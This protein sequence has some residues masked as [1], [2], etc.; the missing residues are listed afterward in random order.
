MFLPLI[1]ISKKIVKM[2]GKCLNEVIDLTLR[3]IFYRYGKIVGTHPGYFIIVP[4]LV[5]VLCFTGVQQ[6][7]Y[8]Y[9]PEY[10][11]SPSNGQ[12]KYER[13]LVETYFP[14]NYSSFKANRI[15]RAGKL[16]RL[17]IKAKDNGSMLRTHIWD[18]MLYLDQVRR[19]NF[20]TT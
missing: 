8:N 3:K 2:G 6:M 12:A 5:T 14:T 4:I 20:S 13:N 9:D 16:G 10:L 15:T 17:I 19:W 1:E 18:Q 11:F 7:N